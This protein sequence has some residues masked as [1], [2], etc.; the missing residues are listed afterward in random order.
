MLNLIN[1]DA[2]YCCTVIKVKELNDIPN[3]DN[4]L[5]MPI[6]GYNAI[7][8]KNTKIGDYGIVFGPETQLSEQFCHFN[9]LFSNAEQNSDKTIKGYIGNNRRVRSIKLRGNFSTCLFL[10]ISALS[11]LGVSLEDIK[12]GDSFTS[13]NGIEVCKKYTIL[14][15]VKNVN[16]SNKKFKER[17]DDKVFPKHIKTLHLMKELDRF[18]G[19]DEIIVT[20]KLHGTSARFTHQLVDRKLS[21]MEKFLSYFVNINKKHYDLFC[22]TRNVIK[23]NSPYEDNFYSHDVWK[24]TLQQIK[25][26]I[27]KNY[28]VYGE[29]VGWAGEKEIQKNYTYCIPKG[30][31]KFFVYRVSIVNE[32]GIQIDLSWDQVKTFCQEKNLNLVPEV[33][34]GKFK[35]FDH[36]IYENKKFLEELNLKQCLPLDKDS[37][38]DEGI[39]VRKE[40]IL[41]FLTKFKSPKFL[42]LETKL[43]DENVS[44]IEDEN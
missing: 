34:R 23:Y 9:N 38:C 42:V 39:V 13:I 33:W 19:E 7:V 2:N 12:E 6:F 24:E 35:N 16:T 3:M 26:K 4:C 31:N 30:T 20:A 8:S 25:D 41:P 11:Y 32:D 22:G 43:L 15:K 28:V 14:E 17:I 27:P 10:P 18:D 21:L 5:S 37:P 29:I 1:E 40:G 36:S 44:S